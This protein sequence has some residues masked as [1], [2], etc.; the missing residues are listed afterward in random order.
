MYGKRH[1]STPIA[2]QS[3]SERQRIVAETGGGVVMPA[4]KIDDAGV[5]HVAALIRG[6]QPGIYYLFSI[7]G[8]KT[9]ESPRPISDLSVTEWRQGMVRH[10]LD[11]LLVDDEVHV[12]WQGVDQSGTG[13]IFYAR[14]FDSGQNWSVPI[15]IQEGGSW[16]KL[17][18]LNNGDLLLSSVG[19]DDDDRI[20]L[21]RQ[22]MSKD[23][24]ETWSPI[25]IIF[26]PVKGCLANSPTIS[27]GDGIPHQVMSAYDSTPIIERI[28]HTVWSE[29]GWEYPEEINWNGISYQDRDL[30]TQPD[31][32]RLAITNGNQLH[33]VFNTDEG[34]I[35]YT[36]RSINA[37]SQ[38]QFTYP[39]PEKE[40]AQ[41][42][43]V[44]ETS[45]IAGE[46]VQPTIEEQSTD[47]TQTPEFSKVSET[48]T[49][50]FNPSFVGLIA[51]LLLITIVVLVTLRRRRDYHSSK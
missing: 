51:V 1:V 16:P 39:T 46:S 25:E 18:L 35:W 34:R 6:S 17:S 48:D 22:S 40:L 41:E 2:A 47:L 15:A 24:G 23:M 10:Q 42:S 4:L 43:T 38:P 44:I 31:N 33:V 26:D 13:S 30:G 19:P 49:I 37:S 11:L 9:W 7:D 3:W 21:K 29:D 45:E 14:G 27:D 5:L 20:C 32:P 12:A 36:S 50:S 28:W 8:G